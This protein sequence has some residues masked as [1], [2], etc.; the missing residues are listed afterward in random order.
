MTEV[1]LSHFDKLLLEL[2]F[3][4]EQELQNKRYAKELLQ[5]Y[6]A[7]IIHE[8]QQIQTIKR[9]ISLSDEIISDLQKYSRNNSDGLV[10]STSTFVVLE[11][12]EEFLQT[13]LE[14]AIKA[15]ENDKNT[16]Q[17]SLEK[18][19]EV[20]KQHEEKYMEF[21]LA[22]EY[23]T[24][25]E[26]LDSVLKVIHTY[27]E[28][29]KLKDKIILDILKPAS[30]G[31]YNEWSLKLAT[32]RNNT[33]KTIHH[34]FQTSR[35]AS[36]IMLKI[37]ELE[38]KIK[39][40]EKESKD[41]FE[42]ENETGREDSNKKQTTELQHIKVNEEGARLTQAKERKPHL[43][44]L[45]NLLQRLMRPPKETQLPLKLSKAG[46]DNRAVV[47]DPQNNNSIVSN[48]DPCVKMEIQTSLINNGSKGII[49]PTTNVQRQGQLRL[50]LI[51]MPIQSKL[52]LKESEVRR[53]Q[54]TEVPD[55][56]K[57]SGYVSEGKSASFEDMDCLTDGEMS[58]NQV[59]ALPQ[60]PSPFIVPD[61]PSVS[62]KTSIR[63]CERNKGRKSQNIT[64]SAINL[65][66]RTSKNTDASSCLNLFKTSTPKT[67]NLSGFKSFATVRFQDQEDSFI[68]PDTNP[69]SP[70]KDIG[71]IFQNMETDDDFSFLFASKPSQAS[72]VEKDDFAFMLPFGQDR[73]NSVE[74]EST[75]SQ[76]KFS[77]F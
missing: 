46:T 64:K 55:N 21:T 34:I 35:T 4:N 58:S 44:Q 51:Q 43:L 36:E 74:S 26:E 47:G 60:I 45:P 32:L 54:F 37:D 29:Q 20:L 24:K 76:T 52:D 69:E 56:S 57:D 49:S 53:Q 39:Y 59:F 11:R 28:Q 9:D 62:T 63:K 17:D 71:N 48:Q 31:S 1:N 40:I 23:H 3:Q 8:K 19:K 65:F 15:T 25:K 12:E 41:I 14:N 75:E 72:D 50:G 2:V 61:P 42:K 73:R 10:M 68:A 70:T 5:R 13:Q 7:K 6:Q 30:F 38:Q 66:S 27:D 77:F 33:N 22:K 67:P 16:F 18:C